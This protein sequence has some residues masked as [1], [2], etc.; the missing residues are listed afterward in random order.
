[1]EHNDQSLGLTFKIIKMKVLQT[2]IYNWLMDLRETVAFKTQLKPNYLLIR[3]NNKN[4][5]L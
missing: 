4:R 3:V 2:K 1:M 5:F